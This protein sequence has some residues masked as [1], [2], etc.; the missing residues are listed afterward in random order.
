[1]K[2]GVGVIQNAKLMLSSAEMEYIYLLSS[3]F[4]TPSF[5]FPLTGQ[6]ACSRVG[7]DL[8][9]LDHSLLIESHHISKDLIPALARLLPRKIRRASRRHLHRLDINN[10]IHEI[11]IFITQMLA[12]QTEILFDGGQVSEGPVEVR[13]HL[14]QA[15]LEGDGFRGGGEMTEDGVGGVLAGE[16]VAEIGGGVEQSFAVG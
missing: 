15:V 9:R 6:I 8:I 16:G 5:Q 10:I 3:C 13:R 1:L 7:P 2:H 11:H 12:Q 4:L 14:R